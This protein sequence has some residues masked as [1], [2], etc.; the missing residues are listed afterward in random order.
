VLAIAL[1]LT[2]SALW[3]FSDFLGGLQTRRHAVL[4]V[5]LGGQACAVVVLVAVV[6]VAGEP[7][8]PARA[9]GW[10]LLAGVGGAIG[11]G[12]LYRS[13]AIGT[14]SI[15]APV[16]AVGAA[17]PFL[18]G[19]ATG[20][21][22]SAVQLAG[23]AL[24]L[25]GVILAARSPAASTARNPPQALV[26]GGVAAVGL[27]IAL[28]GIGRATET[29][30]VPWA[31]LGARGP[32][33]ALVAVAALITRPALPRN[34]AELLPIAAIG[35]VDLSANAL[36]ALATE[37]GLLSLVSV[38][39]SL[40]PAFTVLLARIVLGERVAPLQDLGIAVT[41]AGVVGISAG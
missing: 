18:A 28:L 31:L 23:V 39:G 24:A 33:L 14:M 21:R 6:V 10:S 26:L 38:V 1:A 16:A 20:E 17:V 37:S 27:G 5:L 12:A 22:P 35:L 8:P 7:L 9:A 25:A 11:L 2:S 40:Y 19:W 36:F 15:V 34:A 30:G 29:A 13:L 41:L 32:Q 4:V 3:G